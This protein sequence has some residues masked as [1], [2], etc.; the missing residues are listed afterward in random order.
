MTSWPSRSLA[1]R[2]PFP[3][4]R[5]RRVCGHRGSPVLL[6]SHLASL[7]RP[8]DKKAA[9]K[10]GQRKAPAPVQAK[11]VWTDEL[12]AEKLDE[13]VKK[14]GMK[15]ATPKEL[16]DQLKVLLANV[17]SAQKKVEIYM[18]IIAIMFD[19]TRYASTAAL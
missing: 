1:R 10:S 8:D 19:R 13:V 5:T 12:I 6:S 7:L 15:K 14:R 16:I 3:T 4:M 9:P 18:Q 2:P 11:I 17:K